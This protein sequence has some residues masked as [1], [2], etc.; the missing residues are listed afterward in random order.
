[1]KLK[2]SDVNVRLK[3]VHYLERT[4]RQRCMSAL[5]AAGDVELTPQTLARFT[6]TIGLEQLGPEVWLASEGEVKQEGQP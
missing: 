2:L 1:M 6:W 4:F 5:R 3:V